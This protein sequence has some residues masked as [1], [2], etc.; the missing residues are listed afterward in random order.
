LIIK[1]SRPSQKRH[2]K[3]IK[4]TLRSLRAAPMQA[5]IAAL[6]PII[7][8]WSRYYIP[9]VSGKV[10]EKMDHEMIY[11]L[12]QWATHRHPHKSRYWIKRKYF[13]TLG[14]DRWRFMT[15]DGLYLAHHSDHAIKR[16]MKVRGTKS[17]YDGDWIYWATKLGKDLTIS[18]RIAKLLKNQTGKC[19]E[20]RLWFE[21]KDLMEVHHQDKDGSNNDLTN[22]KLLHGHCHDKVHQEH[23]CSA[24]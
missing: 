11:K 9:A 18:P 19:N 14:N 16:H 10:F 20:C 5:I 24:A 2:S 15:Q 7:N 21:A 3:I 8:G 6:N 12:W 4:D 13:R 22:L 17:P 23:V 1:P